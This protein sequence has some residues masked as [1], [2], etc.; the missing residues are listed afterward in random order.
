MDQQEQ[1]QQRKVRDAVRRLEEYARG[2]AEYA[3]V[4]GDATGAAM[5]GLIRRSL[6]DVEKYLGSGADD[7]LYTLDELNDALVDVLG[8]DA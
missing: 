2:G 7:A 1:N 3:A 4:Q 5:F 8:E 6:A